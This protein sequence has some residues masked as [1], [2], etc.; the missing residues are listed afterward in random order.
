[1]PHLLQTVREWAAAQLAAVP[2][3]TVLEA[4]PYPIAADQLPALIV[5]TG[6]APERYGID[7]PA[8]LAHD[9]ELSVEI[10]HKA[11]GNAQPAAMDELTRA[12]TAALA[13]ARTVA[14]KSVEV[15][16]IDVPPFALD[17]GTDQPVLRRSLRL[18]VAPFFVLAAAPE[19]P[20]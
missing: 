18:T 8:V 4:E 6:A 14:G 11:S 12:V 16:P 2:G 7:A 9:V 5:A 13:G 1:M 15:I 20:V 19:T 17:A 10:I 3:A